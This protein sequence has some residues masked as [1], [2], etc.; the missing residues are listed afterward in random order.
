MNDLVV[1][2][3][4][5]FGE[6]RGIE[7]NGEPWLVGKD[8]A[9]SLRYSN[10]N[11]AIADHVDDEDKLNSKSLSSFELNLGQRG[12]WLINESG[13]YSLVFSSK[14][15]KAKEF[16]H[17]VTAEVLP[18]IRKTGSYSLTQKQDSYLIEDPIARAER[19]IEEQK[20][21]RLLE[22]KV[23][24][25]EKEIEYKE[26][27]IIGLVDNISLAD[28]R[29]ILNRVVRY[30]HANYQER[31]NLL[32]REFENKYHLDLSRRVDTYN[33][34]HKPKCKTKLEYID[35]VMNKI[36]ELYE[37]AAKLFEN[38]V[39]ELVQEMYNVA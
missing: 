2:T 31:W 10:P 39:K 21:K 23:V 20:E 29:Q 7:I 38:D 11:E 19:W 28:K 9:E 12:G 17:W 24:E 5:Q 15:P 36:P 30:K 8:V 34:T 22:T 1:F 14:L 3:N 6:V 13:F 4:N 33:E 26:D 35:R 32:Y 27:V 37:L 16:K 25:Q 18:S